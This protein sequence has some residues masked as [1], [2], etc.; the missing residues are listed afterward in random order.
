M[1]PNRKHVLYS[2]LAF[3]R[4]WSKQGR[5]N[6]KNAKEINQVIKDE[7]EISKLEQKSDRPGFLTE[8][9]TIFAG[10]ISTL[11]TSFSGLIEP[12]WLDRASEQKQSKQTEEIAEPG[13]FSSIAVFAELDRDNFSPIA[14]GLRPLLNEYTWWFIG[15]L[16]ILA[17]SIMG[18][19]EAWFHLFGVSRLSLAL[20]ALFLYQLLFASLGFLLKNKSAMTGKILASIAIFLLP[21]IY[22]LCSLILLESAF[23]GVIILVI[24]SFA[25]IFLLRFIS[26]HFRQTANQI[27]FALLPALIV[28]ALLPVAT[29]K[30]IALFFLFLP[31][32][33][34]QIQVESV[35]RK[36]LF[37][38]RMILVLSFYVSAATG[39]AFIYHHNYFF[40]KNNL[41]AI[42]LFL[43]YLISFSYSLSYTFFRLSKIF[44]SFYAVIDIIF[45]AIVLTITSAVMFVLSISPIEILSAFI[46]PLA[47]VFF[48]LHSIKRYVRS[49]HPFMLI[50]IFASYLFGYK[51]WQWQQGA[52]LLAGLVPI[53][54]LLYYNRATERLQKFILFWHILA[55]GLLFTLL[56]KS[57]QLAD[58]D[59]SLL[60]F[61]ILLAMV[62]HFT[63]GNRMHFCHSIAGLG[64]LAI[65]EAITASLVH[66]DWFFVYAVSFGFLAILYSL[67]AKTADYSFKESERSY[68][69]FDDV[70]LLAIFASLLSFLMSS[71]SSSL[72]NTNF[73][74]IGSFIVLRS[75]RDKS[76]LV[77]YIG[78]LLLAMALNNIMATI[79]PFYE[80]GIRSFWAA[81]FSLIFSVLAGII[82]VE[83]KQDKTDRTRKILALF[84]LPFYASGK[85]LL[86]DGIAALAI[87][88]WFYAIFLIANWFLLAEFDNRM[89]VVSAG[90]ATSL[91]MVCAFLLPSFSFLRLRG[92]LLSLL[93]I[94]IFTGLTFA[95]NRIG[96]PISSEQSGRNL[97]LAI[98]VLTTI[99]LFFKKYGRQ[100]AGYLQYKRHG[101]LYSYVPIYSILLLAIYAISK[102]AMSLP[103]ERIDFS[104]WQPTLLLLAACSGFFLVA[105]F[106]Q[107]SLALHTSFALFLFFWLSM[108]DY[109]RNAMLSFAHSIS[110]STLILTGFAVISLR[111]QWSLRMARFFFQKRAFYHLPVIALLWAKITIILLFATSW[112][113]AFLQPGGIILVCAVLI[114]FWGQQKHAAILIAVLSIFLILQG[115]CHL[116][117]LYLVWHGPFFIFSALLL[118]IAIFALTRREESNHTS[119]IHLPVL[120][121][122]AIGLLYSFATQSPAQANSVWPGLLSGVLHGLSGKFLQH[123]SVAMS[124]F[125][126]IIVLAIIGLQKQKKAAVFYSISTGILLIIA[127]PVAIVP[128]CRGRQ[129]FLRPANFQLIFSYFIILPA[130]LS[131]LSYYLYRS[132]KNFHRDFARGFYILTDGFIYLS[133]SLLFLWYHYYSPL[134]AHISILAIFAILLTTLWATFLEKKGRYLYYLQS[135]IAALYLGLKALFPAIFSSELD[136]IIALLFGF[137]LVG[138]SSI[139]YQRGLTEISQATRRFSAFIPILVAFVLPVETSYKNAG[140]LGISSLLYAALAM[141]SSHRIYVVLAAF[142]A[143]LSLFY[144]IAS[145]DFSGPQT[146][147]APIGLFT[148]MLGHVFRENLTDLAKKWT[149]LAGSILLY[150]PAAIH[151]SFSV[152]SSVAAIYVIIFGIVCLLGIAAGMIFKIRSYLFMGLGFF[153]L[154]ILANL[155]R[156][157]LRDQKMGFFLLTLSGLVIIGGLIYYTVHKEELLRKYKKWQTK[158]SSWDI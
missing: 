72:A 51:Y 113:V 15:I 24:L 147:L 6:E 134:L 118:L 104:Q 45:L 155:V 133:A 99:T 151:I 9:L 18:L 52:L 126:T 88:F 114:Y 139:A 80:I 154:V 145:A 115:V 3:I 102:L 89:T 58:L 132:L 49:F 20:S 87:S 2:M 81:I 103:V 29:N 96:R 86:R 4:L 84:R 73:I 34:W 28:V 101:N 149:R 138:A 125:L 105:N 26:L 44:S 76:R 35:F 38:G 68:Q 128:F 75:F 152:G 37:S 116:A 127:I 143:N 33:F 19:R 11:I 47:A 21:L 148:L 146:Y 135:S 7:L 78:F 5:I 112:Q 39:I 85:L 93:A 32:A 50:A 67:L 42:F 17:G 55:G 31:L 130:I 64:A 69:P 144:A 83:K 129:C 43:L 14:A 90:I 136:P 92:S 61:G 131:A 110:Y 16:M 124:L 41:D 74:A 106:L 153:T 108:T 30:Y 36:H 54:S 70:A 27:I 13:E 141:T 98:G 121:Y 62:N 156:A 77:S 65:V 8:I 63:A 12:F 59:W 100:V 157:G 66:G 119:M 60:I 53:L 48:F 111:E 82:P 122:V 79:F 57:L 117:P 94:F 158:L 10:W 91:V 97:L 120:F 25:I 56:Q 46:V 107:N 140:M 1:K 95:A 109:S 22:S 142:L 150:L 71:N 23:L 123:Y 40:T 137:F